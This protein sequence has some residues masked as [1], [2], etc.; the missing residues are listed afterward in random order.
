M[1]KRLLVY[2]VFVAVLILLLLLLCKS[3]R[4]GSLI[5]DGSVV[6][7][8]QGVVHGF[9]IVINIV[10]SLFDKSI[11]IYEPH[12]TGLGYNIGFWVGVCVWFS[13]GKWSKDWTNAHPE[14]SKEQVRIDSD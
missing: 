7:F 2:G 1:N 8:W 11:G 4:T 10:R 5:V 3:P 9:M 12:N 6:G 14:K 13:S